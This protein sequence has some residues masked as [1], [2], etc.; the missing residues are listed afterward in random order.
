[1][2]KVK[3]KKRIK[4]K[5][6]VQPKR[7]VQKGEMRQDLVTGKWV[8][9]ATGRSKKPSDF[10]KGRAK[11]KRPVKF[12]EECPFCSLDR[13]P[14]EPDVLRLPDD[15]DDW[16]VHIFGN[17]YPALRPKDEFRSW[18]SGPYRAIESVGYHELLAT[19]WHNEV[20]AYLTARQMSMQMEALV[21]RY[22]QLKEK[23]SVSYIQIIKNHGEDAGASLEHPHHQMFTV[24]VLPS[25][26]GDFL[27]GAE[28]YAEKNGH[29]VYEV[30][31]D[32]ELREKERVIFENEKFVAFCPYASRV[33]FEVWVV[34]KD[35]NPYFENLKPRE[36]D[37]LAEIMIR[38]L[39][40]LYVGLNDPPYNY[41]IHSAP[42]DDTG[43]A[44]ERKRWPNF[45]WHIQILPRLAKRG[46][47]EMGTGLEITTALPEE[48]ARFLREQKLEGVLEGGK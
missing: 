29:G 36:R 8:V 14:Q 41:Y 15:P 39:A 9:I 22:R 42:C 13:F 26:V 18:Q 40:S 33:N 28:K 2:S 47:F 3:T 43:F 6:K 12:E 30:V 16:E 46:G 5:K 4:K 48:S 35:D 21:L 1:V 34:P 37:S 20:D 17:K 23:P 24:P 31:V 32:H 44:S 45:R 19:R 38:V 25:D 7:N 11:P 10:T 27:E